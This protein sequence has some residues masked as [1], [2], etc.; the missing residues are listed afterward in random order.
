MIDLLDK[1]PLAQLA[2]W[3]H[4]DFYQRHKIEMPADVKAGR[5]RAAELI[6]RLIDKPAQFKDALMVVALICLDPLPCSSM[7]G[8]PSYGEDVQ[9]LMDK[10]VTATKLPGQPLQEDTAPLITIIS[11]IKMEQAMDEVKAGKLGVT[12][13][14][15][16][17]TSQQCAANDAIYLPHLHNKQVQDLYE[18]TQFAYFCLLERAAKKAPKP[19]APPPPYGPVF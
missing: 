2:F 18:T 6:D 16:K 9:K 5:E 17:S 14:M 15:L 10:L 11:V 7:Y 19:P 13:A 8:D 4:D 1:Y 12:P 3:E